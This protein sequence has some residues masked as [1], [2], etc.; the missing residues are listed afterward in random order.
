MYCA[1]ITRVRADEREQRPSWAELVAQTRAATLADLRAQVE[2]LPRV[3]RL[4]QADLIRR[5]DVL[6]LFDGSS[7]G[8]G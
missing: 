7:D 6:A 4:A 5:A 2:A 1:L 3:S 8:Q